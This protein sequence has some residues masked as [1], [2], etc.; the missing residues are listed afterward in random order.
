MKTKLYLLLA[1]VLITGLSISSC[2]KE[3]TGGGGG[4][5]T[6]SMSLKYDGT[7][8]NASLAVQAVN[9]NGVLNVT[10]S[11]SNGNQASVILYQ[12]S[13]TGTYKVGPN[14]TNQGN[15]LRWTEGLSQSD[16]YVASFV[17]GNGTVTI[18]ELTDSKVSGTFEFEGFNTDQT[19]RTV[20]EGSFSAN[21]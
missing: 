13:G 18:T 19:K 21:F 8:W 5:S 17:I 6:G 4:T 12:A 3:D 9:T 7:A 16:T 20:T 1:A 15:Q 11:D 14:G 10:G 2:K